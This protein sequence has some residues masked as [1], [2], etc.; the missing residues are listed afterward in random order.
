MAFLEADLDNF[1]VINDRFGHHVGD[2]YLAEIARVLKPGGML[3]ITDCA[4][5]WLYGPHDQAMHAR[6]RYS[7]GELET[8]VKKVGFKIQRSSFIF[9]NTFPL[10]LINRLVAKLTLKAGSD[11]KPLPAIVNFFLTTLGRWEASLLSLIN[12]PW[13]SSIIILARK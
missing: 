12:L 8:K 7:K 11:V 6:Q 9:M 13:G 1:K 10:F 3:L 4:H 5:Q 2:R